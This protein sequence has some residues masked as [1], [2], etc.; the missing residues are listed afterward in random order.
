MLDNLRIHHKSLAIPLLPLV[1]LAVAAGQVR[2]SVMEGAL[3]G[4]VN[5]LVVS[6]TGPRTLNSSKRPVTRT[7]R[8]G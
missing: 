8:I 7:R 2:S 1:L 4:R 3:A 6:T 5:A